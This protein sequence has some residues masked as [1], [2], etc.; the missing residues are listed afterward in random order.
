MNRPQVEGALFGK[1]RS[2]KRI[3][4]RP[5]IG[6]GLQQTNN[7]A[8]NKTLNPDESAASLQLAASSLSRIG[9]DECEVDET[10]SSNQSSESL[11][12]LSTSNSSSTA[13]VT[14]T[15][16]SN[17]TLC[18]QDSISNATNTTDL[19]CRDINSKRPGFGNSTGSSSNSSLHRY[20]NQAGKASAVKYSQSSL[21][22][23]EEFASGTENSEN[24]TSTGTSQSSGSTALF[25]KMFFGPD[26]KVQS[27]DYAASFH[28]SEENLIPGGSGTAE[29]DPGSTGTPQS[30]SGSSSSE[31]PSV[32]TGSGNENHVFSHALAD[33]TNEQN[34][35]ESISPQ[36]NYYLG[37]QP[38][39]VAQASIRS[40]HPSPL[41]PAATGQSTSG[42]GNAGTQPNS[43]GST[44]T[45]TETNPQDGSHLQNS[46]T[47]P[48]DYT[49]PVEASLTT[50]TPG[51]HVTQGSLTSPNA[52]SGGGG[53]EN[54]SSGGNTG[55]AGSSSANAGVQS[56]AQPSNP[57]D[58]ITNSRRRPA[59]V[60]AGKS[61]AV[62]V[63]SG[64]LANSE[65]KDTGQGSSSSPS[66]QSPPPPESPNPSIGASNP[67]TES[68][69]SQVGTSNPEDGKSSPVSGGSN[70]PAT[71][72][73]PQTN[74]PKPAVG[75]TNS[76]QSPST[77]TNSQN[78]GTN[79]NPGVA[80]VPPA[81]SGVPPSHLANLQVHG[82]A[83]EQQPNGDL[84]VG[85]QII[86][87]GEAANVDGVP[88]SNGPED[89]K[90]N[91]QSYKVASTP[92][93]PAAAPAQAQV[94]NFSIP[95]DGS[96]FTIPVPAGST[97][98]KPALSAAL[99]GAE[100][101][102]Q[103]NDAGVTVSNYHPPSSS[104]SQSN[105]ST[106]PPVSSAD[107]DSVKA[108]VAQAFTLPSSTGTGVTPPSI[109]IPKDNAPFTIPIP[110]GSSVNIS[111]L[112]SAL[113]GASL[114]PLP[115]NS[116][117]S[118]TGYN[119]TSLAANVPPPDQ[120]TLQTKAA[121]LK[122]SI[123]QSF[124][125]TTGSNP[126]IAPDISIPDDGA[127]FTIPIPTG[128]TPPSEAAIKA[129]LPGAKVTKLPNNAG[130]S[131]EGY[132]I[133]NTLS[134][135]SGAGST[136]T[137]TQAI[138]AKKTSVQNELKA[139]FPTSTTGATSDSAVDLPNLEIPTN[140]TEPFTIP[141]PAGSDVDINKLQT[142]LPGAKLTKSAD[143]KSVRVEGFS[144][145]GAVREDQVR[146]KAETGIKAA[147]L[148]PDDSQNLYV[149]VP[150]GGANSTTTTG[151]GGTNAT[152][153]ASGFTTLV[154]PS[155]TGT[156]VP[157]DNGIPAPDVP[158]LVPVAGNGDGGGGG[159]KKNAAV[160]LAAGRWL[161]ACWGI[162]AGA[163]VVLD[164]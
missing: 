61:P 146:E 50:P 106:A 78:P 38:N 162:G 31:I 130:F 48:D 26:G 8:L 30:F 90:V 153:T 109:S 110:S 7:N 53:A 19:P 58:I 84:K 100:I 160:R 119:P 14:N 86:P 102:V 32:G 54:E 126:A 149:W 64:T 132:N 36:A 52:G 41:P 4:R 9:D 150:D 142:A 99:P 15:L 2:V 92:P 72:S 77:D 122:T 24:P 87:K 97:V 155:A 16:L 108:K 3:V 74:N 152:A 18:L 82:Q 151:T 116:G 51:Y 117:V 42:S 98:N 129:A 159:G 71:N 68:T 147:F 75:V 25:S 88:V 94:P 118:V 113:P 49:G 65:T 13:N 39:L 67:P 120:S 103:P 12:T 10:Q 70:Q 112:S 85:S 164:L 34:P 22:S 137:A 121:A 5:G 89:V 6:L 115:D 136:D 62:K 93:A 101:S 79:S 125:P 135:P 45:Q 123:A 40:P 131:V 140:S 107:E 27:G 124:S 128:S 157:I 66:P 81:S 141:I 143:G 104:S 154:S 23:P 163:L 161:W 1:R 46:E 29:S 91:G 144:V 145:A 127:P 47:L 158:N 56:S 17:G 111:S 35:D 60:A 28:N 55:N 20:I 134:L 148:A 156:G 114:T 21:I 138:A 44:G 76:N 105:P 73:N 43:S 63:P 33:H 83:I 95:K 80:S 59:G 139:A 57:P 37:A 96:P 69:N 133:R 11:S